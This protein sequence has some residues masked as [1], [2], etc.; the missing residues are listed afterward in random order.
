MRAPAVALPE[1]FNLPKP[2]PDEEVLMPMRFWALCRAR[3]GLGADIDDDIPCRTT[4][5]IASRKAN[6]RASSFRHKLGQGF[7]RE[8]SE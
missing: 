1:A 7:A 6:M 2:D 3:M 4:G 8:G 5:R